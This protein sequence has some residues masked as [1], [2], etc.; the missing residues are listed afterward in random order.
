MCQIQQVDSS[1]SVVSGRADEQIQRK[2]DNMQKSGMPKKA[3]KTVE[4]ML[5]KRQKV[6]Q[7]A[8]VNSEHLPSD[9]MKVDK[10]GED[11]LAVATRY[12]KNALEM[13]SVY[14]ESIQ[15]SKTFL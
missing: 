12:T 13:A 15:A 7:Q 6:Q 4:K 5:K 10:Y 2:L 9:L 3:I 1:V 8:T 14:T 11:V